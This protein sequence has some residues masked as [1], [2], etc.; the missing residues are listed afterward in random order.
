MA[1]T[2]LTSYG[3]V[4][5]AYK[6]KGVDKN[7]LK[8]IKNIILNSS[9]KNIKSIINNKIMNKIKN[10]YNKIIYLILLIKYK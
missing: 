2:I 4:I 7:T 1:A 8:S 9:D 10:N 3:F 5:K 6:F